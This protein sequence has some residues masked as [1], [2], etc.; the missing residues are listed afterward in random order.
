MDLVYVDS[1]IKLL[2]ATILGASIGLERGQHGRPAGIRTHALVCLAS[3][4]LIMVTRIGAL[5]AMNADLPG[6]LTFNIDPA[7]MAAG[8]VMGVGF[9]GAGAN[10]RIRESLI[11]GL[12]TA[13]CIWFVAAIGVVV[14]FD[15]Y[16]L[17]IGAVT[18]AL[19]IL[20]LLDRVEN[21]MKRVSYRTVSVDVINEQK[22]DVAR[23]CRDLFR[24][25]KMKVQQVSY[26]VDNRKNEAQFTF[27]LRLSTQRNRLGLVSAISAFPGVTCVRWSQ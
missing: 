3:T 10:F 5:T 24:K 16:L 4:L 25:S 11:R 27:S 6:N 22:E 1:L 21:A 12:T 20:V 17:A 9:M 19:I 7:R 8:I 15:H 18:I 13:A 26:R 14:G 23:L 2:L